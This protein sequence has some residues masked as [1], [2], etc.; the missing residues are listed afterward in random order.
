MTAQKLKDFGGNE[1]LANEYSD[2]KGCASSDSGYHCSHYEEE[3]KEF[4]CCIC[5]EGRKSNA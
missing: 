5:G 3:R 4:M 1:L 2:E